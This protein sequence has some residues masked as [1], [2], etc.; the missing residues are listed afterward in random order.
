MH[1]GEKRDLKN[2]EGREDAS[3]EAVCKYSRGPDP[4]TN[5]CAGKGSGQ[6][7]ITFLSVEVQEFLGPLIACSGR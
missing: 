7:R 4:L 3:S 5:R 6:T 1:S 2:D